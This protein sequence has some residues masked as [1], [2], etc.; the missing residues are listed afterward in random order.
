MYDIDQQRNVQIGLLGKPYGV[1][2][3]VLLFNHPPFLVPIVSVLS[4]GNYVDSYRRWAAVLF[5]IALICSWIVYLLLR[6]AGHTATISG[7]A[8]FT[9]LLFYPSYRSIEIGTDTIV[10]LLGVLLW[11]LFL[12]KEKER[13]AG[14]ALSLTVIKPHL[15]LVLAAVTLARSRRA[16]SNLPSWRSC[17]NGL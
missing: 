7:L 12:I 10:A 5:A 9:S 15:A 6:E 8:A 11:G 13:A 3:G 16:F 1:P 14:L 2:A 4:N 17:N